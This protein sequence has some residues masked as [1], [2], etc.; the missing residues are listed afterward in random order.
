MGI[1]K[2]QIAKHGS[3]TGVKLDTLDKAETY[4]RHQYQRGLITFEEMMHNLALAKLE[5][6]ES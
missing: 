6:T 2:D 1:Y 5:W 4:I 3:W